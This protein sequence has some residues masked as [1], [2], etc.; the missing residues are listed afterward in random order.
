MAIQLAF[1]FY[2]SEEPETKAAA[3]SDRSQHL[4]FK[5]IAKMIAD[6]R[7]PVWAI[8]R[9]IAAEMANTIKQMKTPVRPFQRHGPQVDLN[10]RMKALREL[11]RT[12]MEG[13]ALTKRDAL[14]LDGPKFMFVRAE[15][16]RLF[17]QA[18]NDAGTESSQT[19]DVMVQ[20]GDL[21]EKN[22][23]ALRRELDI[24]VPEM[25]A[26]D[27]WVLPPVLHGVGWSAVSQQQS[28]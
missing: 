1:D 7:A 11:Q 23:E 28:A 5:A 16:V 25:E 15:I 26:D 22:D 3:E 24:A 14:D 4:R 20:F 6:R 8:S 18:L 9:K 10:S 27:K 21:M 2:D 13:E 19:Q 17:Q 12:L